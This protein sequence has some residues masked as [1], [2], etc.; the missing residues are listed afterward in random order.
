[1]QVKKMELSV[2]KAMERNEASKGSDGPID[3]N[4][5]QLAGD[6]RKTN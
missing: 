2:K 5:T 1:M 3:K 4:T 6:P